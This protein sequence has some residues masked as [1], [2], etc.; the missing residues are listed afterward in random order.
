MVLML[1]MS[2]SA[3][4]GAYLL[5][6]FGAAP[7]VVLFFRCVVG[8]V[9]RIS[10]K[11]DASTIGNSRSRSLMKVPVWMCSELRLRIFPTITVG[12]CPNLAA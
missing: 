8:L 10:N 1:P 3:S 11:D 7:V 9:H 12:L 6:G 2:M 4:F 5:A